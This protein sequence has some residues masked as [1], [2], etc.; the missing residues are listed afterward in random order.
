MKDSSSRAVSVPRPHSALRFGLWAILLIGL[1]AAFLALGS[2]QV[3]RL[4]GKRALIARIE[5]R[6]HAPPRPAPAMD[7]WLK[8]DPADYEYSRVQV[9]GIFLNDKE[10]QV[11]AVTDLG[12]G[13][14]VLT[15]L[16]AASGAVTIINRGFVPTDHRDPAT[17]TAGEIVGPT[18][19][20]GL[21]RLSEPK[22]TLLRSNDPGDERWYSRDV[23]AIAADRGLQGEI[24]YFIDADATPN[25]GGMP[26]GGLTQ[27]VFPN[28]HL[29][30]AV[31]WFGLAA[32][33][34]V[35]TGYLFYWERRGA[36]NE[37]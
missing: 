5:A 14:W 37:R 7:E 19:V 12:P 31:T 35:M 17:R 8:A 25:P 27:L 9:A 23:A 32:L 29:I 4:Y 21:L 24:P 10:T 18:T 15:P 36:R 1:S 28:N 33:S 22:G 3:A 6:V 13:Y 26:V 34:L 11:Y 2:W 30:Y 20:T 16:K